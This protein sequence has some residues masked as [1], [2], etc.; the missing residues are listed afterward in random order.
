MN[1]YIY[2]YYGLSNDAWLMSNPTQARFYEPSWF[3]VLAAQSCNM[4]G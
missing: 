1:I 3:I 2:I 4:E